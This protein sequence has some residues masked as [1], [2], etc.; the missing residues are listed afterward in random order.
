[1]SFLHSFL[2]FSTVLSRKAILRAL[3]PLSAITRFT[4]GLSSSGRENLGLSPVSLLVDRL[5]AGPP[6][7]DFLVIKLLNAGIRDVRKACPTVKR[8]G[9]GGAGRGIPPYHQG[10]QGG[11]T[12]FRAWKAVPL[13]GYTQH[14]SAPWSASPL[15]MGELR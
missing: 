15:P 3:R 8:E 7:V 9:E 13:L 10:I 14:T 11:L 12:V 6:N 5:G 4:V 1:M 2:L